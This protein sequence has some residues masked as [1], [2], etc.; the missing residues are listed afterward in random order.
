[1]FWGCSGDVLKCF[2]DIS[3]ISKA[4]MEAGIGTGLTVKDY[5]SRL[6]AVIWTAREVIR[7]TGSAELGGTLGVS[8]A[9]FVITGTPRVM[10]LIN[11]EEVIINDLNHRKAP[12][13]SKFP[14]LLNV[15]C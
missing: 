12:H 11:S 13:S 9:D 5:W 6:G 2:D 1:M 15:L 8:S 4:S 3:G 7:R 10:Q 14:C